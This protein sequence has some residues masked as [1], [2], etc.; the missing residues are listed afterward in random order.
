M[1]KNNVLKGINASFEEGKFYAIL[2]ESG[3]GKTTLLSLIAGLDSIQEGD[4]LFN[5]KSLKKIGYNNYRLKY[6]NIIFQAYN[7]ISYMT[8]V[9][10]VIVAMDIM[11]VKEK[12]KKEYALKLLEKLG[13]EKETAN[14]TVLKL[15]GGEQQRTA[16]ARCMVGNVP[17]ILADEP[18]GNLDEETEEKIINIFK[19]LTKEGKCVI[20]VT[21]SRK[22]ADNADVI[23][24]IKKGLMEESI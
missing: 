6:A 16:I 10:N 5:D 20:V 14:R 4:I 18:T 15:S 21:H 12:N 7:L 13:I 11:K 23:F 1:K 19:D 3:S 8:A 22:V 9:E 24:K 17:I 2:G